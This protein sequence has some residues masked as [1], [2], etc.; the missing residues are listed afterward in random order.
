MFTVSLVHTR[1]HGPELFRCWSTEST[2]RHSGGSHRMPFQDG[3]RKIESQRSPQ[4]PGDPQV[5]SEVLA[6]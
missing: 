3:T 5:E 1:D 2:A 6:A 4:S